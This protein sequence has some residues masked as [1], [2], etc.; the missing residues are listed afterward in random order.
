MKRFFISLLFV[1]SFL[2]AETTAPVELP[3]IYKKISQ[4]NLKTLAQKDAQSDTGTLNDLI[5]DEKEFIDI[6]KEKVEAQLNLDPYTK[7]QAIFNLLNTYEEKHAF[8]VTDV[9]E[10]GTWKDL[11]ILCGPKTLPSLYL[12]A[13][14]DRTVTEVGRAML[15]RKIIQ[16][17]DNFEELTKQQT[18][19]KTLVENDALFNDL[20]S[21]LRKLAVPESVF[22]SFWGEDILSSIIKQNKISLPF[23]DKIALLKKIT[24]SINKNEHLLMTKSV[25]NEMFFI[26]SLAILAAT[27]ATV[28][29]E[30]GAN[31]FGWDLGKNVYGGETTCAGCG[32]SMLDA[33]K[34]NQCATCHSNTTPNTNKS[35]GDRIHELNSMAPKQIDLF[36]MTGMIAKVLEFPL[37]DNK[38]YKSTVRLLA[39]SFA[40][41]HAWTMFR[42][43]REGNQF[44]AMMHKKLANLATY[45][46]SVNNMIR[47]IKKHDEICR[48]MPQIATLD[49]K[50]EELRA[51]NE[52]FDHLLNLLATNTFKGEHSFFSFW[53]R[54]SVAYRL[55]EQEKE[56]FDEIMFAIGELDAQMSIARLYKEMKGK[57]VE[58]CFPVYQK[59]DN[60]RPFIKINDFWHPCLDVEKAVPS[61]IDILGK[62][63]V[64]TGPNAGGKSTIM[65]ALVINIIIA[66]ALGIAAAKSL[67]FTLFSKI[68]T[69]MNITDDIAAGNSHFKAGVIRARDVLNE[70]GKIKDDQFSLSVVD[71]LFNGTTF[72]EGQAAAYGFINQ[73]GQKTNNIVITTTHFPLMA[74]LANTNDRFLNYKVYVTYDENGKIVYPFK[75]EQGASDQIVTLRILEEE[76]FND[77]FMH[78]ANAVLGVS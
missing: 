1:F 4:E 11:E 8:H 71:E 46:D 63:I 23:E 19:V 21:N 59:S 6:V 9:L 66:Q 75:L 49:V 77:Q 70:I 60:N 34:F 32:C 3:G 18:I 56:K 30:T 24:T 28:P 51:L 15:Y 17:T 33:A 39:F 69:Y 68:V 45:V 35:F 44:G 48:L 38:Y 65:K 54:K 7:R 16:P 2:S 14:V 29:L 67:E 72:K 76:G 50:M 43:F 74:S 5:N 10:D 25:A 26:L 61:S 42:W 52:D 40:A 73:L 64:I 57:R 47:S 41:Y 78:D 37:G 53:S 12:A 13:K 58:Y 31:Y 36:S 22:L 55:M 20:D 62:N 27:T